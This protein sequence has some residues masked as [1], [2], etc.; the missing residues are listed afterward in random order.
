MYEWSKLKLHRWNGLGHSFVDEK[1]GTTRVEIL[2]MRT[3]NVGIALMR[4]GNLGFFFFFGK[5][6]LKLG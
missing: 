3:T 4:I 1:L 5:I 6:D 2:L